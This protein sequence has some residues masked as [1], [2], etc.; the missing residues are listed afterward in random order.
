[1]MKHR[2][3]ELY[4]EMIHVHQST[5]HKKNVNNFYTKIF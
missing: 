2:L 3:N 4:D 1:M 5:F